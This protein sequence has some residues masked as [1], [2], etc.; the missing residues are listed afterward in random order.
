MQEARADTIRDKMLKYRAK[1]NISQKELARRAGLTER[2]VCLIENQ[3]QTPTA[4]TLT[5]IMM[6]LEEQEG[7][8]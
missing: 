7:T 1:N 5:K 3:A 8:K 4:R 2:T 6:V